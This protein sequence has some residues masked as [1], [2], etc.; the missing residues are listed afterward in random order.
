MTHHGRKEGM[1]WGRFL[2]AVAVAFV[3]VALAGCGTTSEEAKVDDPFLPTVGLSVHS[4]SADT[5]EGK[6]A[7][8]AQMRM[9]AAFTENGATVAVMYMSDGVNAAT[10]GAFAEIQVP[11]SEKLLEQTGIEAETLDDLA[12]ALADRGVRFFVGKG[13]LNSR[14]IST[15]NLNPIFELTNMEAMAAMI[16]S[17]E[18]VLALYD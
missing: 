5:T 9:A 18:K 10:R 4:F 15:E 14:G 13:G 11:N 17:A 7:A 2:I 3:A 8:W 1:K 16:L 6:D 12:N